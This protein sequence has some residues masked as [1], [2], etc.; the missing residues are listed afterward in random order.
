[1]NLPHLVRDMGGKMIGKIFVDYNYTADCTQGNPIAEP[2]VDITQLLAICS[3][4]PGL[5]VQCGVIWC[6]CPGREDAHACSLC[7]FYWSEIAADLQQLFD[8][9]CNP[10]YG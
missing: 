8:T 1:M 9:A 7:E 3:N 4:N 10:K 2:D 6:D 5:R